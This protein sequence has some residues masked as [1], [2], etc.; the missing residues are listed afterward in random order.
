MTNPI[1]VYVVHTGEYSDRRIK[2][3]TKKGSLLQLPGP[4]PLPNQL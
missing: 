3:A 1:K 4:V 2:V